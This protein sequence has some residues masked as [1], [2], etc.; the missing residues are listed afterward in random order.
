MNVV[1]KLKMPILTFKFSRSFWN[2]SAESIEWY[3][4]GSSHS[5][6]RSGGELHSLNFLATRN[7]TNDCVD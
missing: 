5:F 2:I 1:R 7:Q 6:S 3:Q 4:D